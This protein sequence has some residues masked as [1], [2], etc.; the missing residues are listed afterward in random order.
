MRSTSNIV[1]KAGYPRLDALNM[2]LTLGR[3][4]SEMPA[5][6][7]TKV[8]EA[9]RVWMMSTSVGG[10]ERRRMRIEMASRSG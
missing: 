5:V 7:G 4:E 1:A 9:N 8:R 3:V 2:S 10:S 6:G